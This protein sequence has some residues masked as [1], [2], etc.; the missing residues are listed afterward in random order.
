MSRAL[1]EENIA[2]KLR[3]PQFRTDISSLVAGDYAWEFDRAAR[4]VSE[5]LIELLPGEPWKGEG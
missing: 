5:G 3:D 2:F 1:F 4:S